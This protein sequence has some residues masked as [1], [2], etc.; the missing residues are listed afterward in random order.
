MWAD[1]R[2]GWTPST[3]KSSRNNRS[4]TQQRAED[5]M[6]EEDLSELRQDR[7]LENT[8]T[9]KSSSSVLGTTQAELNSKSQGIGGGI[10]GFMQS[11]IE[12]TKSSIGQQ[13][14]IKQGW[15]LGQGI[16]PRIS[17]K[18]RKAQI[19]KS[20]YGL[21]DDEEHEEDDDVVMGDEEIGKKNITF[22][23]KDTRLIT[24]EQKDDKFG[25]GYI[26]GMNLTNG[27]GSNGMGGLGGRDKLKLRANHVQMLDEDD[28]D[29]YSITGPST[30]G[31]G[32]FAF[33]NDE[34]EDDNIIIGESSSFRN[35]NIQPKGPGFGSGNERG[36]SRFSGSTRN[37]MNGDEDDK[38][39]WHDGRPV[40]N[41]FE[42]DPLGVPPDKWFE[43]PDIPDDWRPRPARVWGT[44][45][46]FDQLPGQ[47]E[48]EK[49]FI[50]GA[51]GKPLTFEQVRP[52]S[53]SVFIYRILPWFSVK[54]K[55]KRIEIDS[56]CLSWQVV[57]Q[58]KS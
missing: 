31:G 19:K 30:G 14:L 46:K 38:N 16:G 27:L 18:K 45:K 41:G 56:L 48:E 40:L 2:I 26:R 4:T 15:K 28:D 13:L 17:G 21:N 1:I 10:G 43:F 9:F 20:G 3:F 54:L 5:F 34:D 25:L 37:G 12:P 8:D 51:P 50:R 22:A 36:Q 24:Y 55:R 23:P 7:K 44:G 53:I 47:K 32:R 35:P 39:R 52:G 42:L 6:D 33:N 58:K 11:L 57:R 49:E 29:P